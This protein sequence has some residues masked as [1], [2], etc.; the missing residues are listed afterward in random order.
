MQIAL[1][2][3][4]NIGYRKIYNA[5][6]TSDVAYSNFIREAESL[7]AELGS[8]KVQPYSMI[9]YWDKLSNLEGVS[10]LK[11]LVSGI[12]P[13]I[14]VNPRVKF[15]KAKFRNTWNGI[16]DNFGK[17]NKLSQANVAM[18]SELSIKVFVVLAFYKS[19]ES[20]IGRFDISSVLEKYYTFMVNMFVGLCDAIVNWYCETQLE[21]MLTARGKNLL[22]LIEY[23]SLTNDVLF[24]DILLEGG[25]IW[26]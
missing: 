14:D 13:L 18:L 7:Y 9:S 21:S 5:S 1:K 11:R 6:F 23:L 22:D 15:A 3:V 12:E 4:R 19:G 25:S 10:G 17:A 20:K 2:D 24:T 26:D 8:L 16:W